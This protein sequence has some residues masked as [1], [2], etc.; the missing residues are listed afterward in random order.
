MADTAPIDGTD[1]ET[2]TSEVVSTVETGA[3]VFTEEHRG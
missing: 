2:I 1:A 3:K